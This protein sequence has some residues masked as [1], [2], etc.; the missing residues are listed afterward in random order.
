[1]KNLSVL[2]VLFLASILGCYKLQAQPPVITQVPYLSN[3][4]GSYSGWGVLQGDKVYPNDQHTTFKVGPRSYLVV[5]YGQATV[6][7]IVATWE[8]NGV[9]RNQLLALFGGNLTQC[10]VYQLKCEKTNPCA[11]GPELVCKFRPQPP[12]GVMMCGGQCCDVAGIV[13]PVEVGTVLNC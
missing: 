1:M 11:A 2:L 5:P 13:L 8:A 6:Q 10:T 3:F 12:L 9:L 4:A 7:M